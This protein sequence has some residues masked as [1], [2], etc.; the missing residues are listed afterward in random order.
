MVLL[1]QKT[2]EIP[3]VSFTVSE[4][5]SAPQTVSE[6]DQTSVCS[7]KPQL[8]TW[9]IHLK[10]CMNYPHLSCLIQFI[11]MPR[12]FTFN[13]NKSFIAQGLLLYIYKHINLFEQV[14]S[15]FFLN[16]SHTVSV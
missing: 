5:I 4:E 1:R 10:W 15:I 12:S 9:T 7:E 11:H 3:C 2:V 6:F 13:P 14:G 8:E 16:V